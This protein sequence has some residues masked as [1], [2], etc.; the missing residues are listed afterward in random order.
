MEKPLGGQG[1]TH[2]A[3]F[4]VIKL[5]ICWQDCYLLPPS[6]LSVREILSR[7]H[8]NVKTQR[9]AVLFFLFHISDRGWGRKWTLFDC[10]WANYLS[11]SCTTADTTIRTGE[12]KKSKWGCNRDGQTQPCSCG[13]LPFVIPHCA[14]EVQWGQME[15]F[16]W[17]PSIISEKPRRCGD[18][19]CRRAFQWGVCVDNTPEGSQLPCPSLKLVNDIMAGIH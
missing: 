13:R 14:F 7:E 5:G 10:S 2:L 6:F 12:K 3:L 17:L 8:N 9:F 18:K 1:V 11:P 4:R 15:T 19:I 16:W